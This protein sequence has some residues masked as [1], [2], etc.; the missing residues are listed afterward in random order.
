MTLLRYR[1]CVLAQMKVQA[2]ALE[3]ESRRGEEWRG[4]EKKGE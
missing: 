3:K 1:K 2:E 4:E